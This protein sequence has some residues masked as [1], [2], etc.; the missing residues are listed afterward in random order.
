MKKLILPLT[1]F[2]AITFSCTTEKPAGTTILSFGTPYGTTQEIMIGNVKTVV[3]KNYWA[4]PDGDSYKKGN[5]LTKADRD[6]LKGW[7]DDFEAFYDEN[8]VFVNG[9]GL[10]ENGIAIWKNESVIQNK[11]IARM[12]TFK[13]DTLQEYVELKYGD[14]GFVI[15]GTRTRAGVDT[16]MESI[17]MKTNAVG[18][19]TEFMVFNPKGESKYKT[20]QTYDEQNRF[21]KLEVFDKDGKINYS[22][23][24]KYNDKGKMSELNIR[25]KDRKVIASNYLTY[26]YDP[27]GNWVRAIVK[28]A[29]NNVIIEE[30]S[31]TYFE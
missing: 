23:E 12:N 25:D 11:Q 26:E 27:K 30:R 21:T 29:K 1:I 6:S 16:L 15:S 5:P 3:E 8:G 24:G 20:A 7:T 28:D 13:N 19:P 9:T 22:Y 4:I 10:D 18:Y 31:Y 14:N 17:T 2:A